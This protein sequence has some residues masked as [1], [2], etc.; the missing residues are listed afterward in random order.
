MLEIVKIDTTQRSQVD[1]FIR[2]HV[3]L[4]Q[5]CPVWVPPLWDEA[6]AQLDR[7][8]NPY[9]EF[10]DADFLLAVQDGRDVGRMAILEN[11]RYNDYKRERVAFFYLFDAVDDLEVSRALFDAG[12]AW[13]RARGLNKI[14][15]PKG[16]LA[17]D[18]F[19]ILV[20]GFEYLPAMGVS[21]NYP[22][23][24]R[25][26]T[27]AGFQKYT[28]I[29]S[30]LL[31]AGKFDIPPRVLELAE[32]VKEKRGITIK[33]FKNKKELSQF[34]PR[35]METYNGMFINNWEYVP[36]TPNETRAIEAR[37]MDIL[38]PDLIKMAMKGDEVIGFLFA[39][40]NVNR[41][42]QKI[43]GRLWPFGF[44]ALLRA[45]QTT[46]YI[47][48]NGFGVLPKH[49][50]GGANAVMYAEIYHT[51][52]RGGFIE[53]DLVQM[54]EGN[55]KIQAEMKALGVTFHKCHRMYYKDLV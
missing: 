4:Y 55:D 13:A 12:A 39:F 7:K 53:A 30:G 37:L 23:Y 1:R 48:L 51:V 27:D 28:D 31:D 11:R 49:Q 29:V 18:A 41:T 2:M 8:R 54:E 45:L 16:F 34:V 50:G 32:R 25:L 14:I 9:F 35:I 21:Y 24:D 44:I 36:L 17:F 42:I 22:Y 5:D 26:L 40:P 52:K 19:G 3:N 38:R 20:Q 6:R 46:R 43:K 47:D 15:G 33:R 10:S